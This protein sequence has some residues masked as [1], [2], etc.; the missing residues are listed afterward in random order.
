MFIDVHYI[1]TQQTKVVKFNLRPKA[2]INKVNETQQV[3][4]QGR[5]FWSVPI[6]YLTIRHWIR[7]PFEQLE[8]IAR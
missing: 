2:G 4:L 6:I 1:N 8:M 7:G 5:T 3:F